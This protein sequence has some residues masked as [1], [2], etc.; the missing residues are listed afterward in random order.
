MAGRRERPL[1]PEAGPLERLAHGLRELRASAGGPTY[2]AMAARA[3]YSVSTLAAAARGDELPSLPVTL[4]YV[5]LCGGDPEEWEARW[6]GTARALEEQ[7]TGSAV[8]DDDGTDPPY[9][10]LARYEPGDRALFFGRDHLLTRL[11]ELVRG[12][13]VV[14]VAGASGSGKSSLLRAGLIPALRHPANAPVRCAGIRVLTPGA[15]P[16][17]THTPVLTAFPQPADAAGGDGGETPG[18]TDEDRARKDTVLVVDQFE[19]LFTLCQEQTE[20]ARFLELLLA[21]RTPDSGLRVV[22]AVRADFYAHCTE[23]PGLVEVLRTAHL[24]LGPMT[25]AE[26]R[27]A[28]VGPARAAGLIV[29]RELTARI[30]AETAVEPGGL[31]LMSHA[32]LEVWRRRRGRTLTLAAYESI[33]G[34]HGAVA[35]TAE[36]TYGR[37][38]PTQAAHARRLLLRLIT[39]GQGS[40]DTRRPTPRAELEADTPDETAQVLE[41]LTR[42]RLVTL[43]GDTADLAHEALITAWPRLANWIQED[44]HRLRVHRRLTRDAQNWQDLGQDTGAL[45]RGIRL[46][47]AREAFPATDHPSDLTALEH[48]FLTASQNHRLTTI[49]RARVLNSVL[50]CVL[51][52]ALLTAGIALWQRQNARTAEQRALTAQRTAESRQA[53]AHSAALFPKDPDLASLL[54]VHAYR[55]SPTTEAIVSLNK[56]A[57]RPLIRSSTGHSR[58]VWEA[59]FSRDG[60]RLVTVDDTGGTLL[61]DTGSG[62]NRRVAGNGARAMAALSPDGR[63]LASLSRHGTL[64]LRDVDSNRVRTIRTGHSEMTRLLLFSPDGRTLATGALDHTVR[65]W[66]A[67]TGKLRAVLTRDEERSRGSDETFTPDGR[68]FVTAAPGAG[69]V[70]LWDVRTGRLGVELIGH[71]GG[72]AKVEFSPDGRTVATAGFNGSVRLTDVASDQSLVLPVG[73]IE[74]AGAHGF[75]PDGRLFATAAPGAGKIRLWD[76]RT[77]KLRVELTGH[78]DGVARVAFSPDGRTVATAGLDGN[79]RLSDVA[80]GRSLVVLNGHTGV[81]HLMKFSRDGRTLMSVGSEGTVRWWQ[82]ETGRGDMTLTGHGK[83]VSAV[84]FSPDGGTLASVGGDRTV[85][86]WDTGT[87]GVRAALTGDPDGTH[88]VAYSPDGRTLA[89]G[90]ND[91]RVRLWDVDT[92]T[93][94]ATLTGHT[95]PVMKIAFSPDGRTL[96]SA[97]DDGTVRLWAVDTGRART[98]LKTGARSMRSVAFSP[99]GRTLATGGDDRKVRLWDVSTGRIRNV[100]SAHSEAVMDVTF[101]PDG[102]TLASA[103]LDDKVR[104]WD[105]TT[106]AIEATLPGGNGDVVFSPDG[107]TLATAGADWEIQLW[108]VATRTVRTTLPPHTDEVFSVAFSPD[109][110]TLAMGSDDKKVRLRRIAMTEPADALHK[111]CRAFQRNLTADERA[112][113]LPGHDSTPTCP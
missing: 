3:G 72:V 75:S 73:K 65:L 64:R 1:D 16:V 7:T 70:R 95:Q 87:G 5:T 9:R 12:H 111:I 99:D 49:R 41:N 102:R 112:Q 61:W 71:R 105:A 43:D 52:L 50:A 26:L 82:A 62:R 78:R 8:R 109:G 51:V 66:D 31:P 94:R 60:R 22:I 55:T 104:L 83:P 74:G 108:D 45:Y 81:A 106:G 86:L 90:G 68:F 57:D 79:I 92:G 56:A 76:V 21:A 39:P 6:H 23:H 107:R 97:S 24:A 19:E 84:A 17:A 27:Q 103:S 38:T 47:E 48:T 37:L 32:L 88:T 11:I 110:R 53:A 91:Q 40:P 10:G 101:S 35:D 98:V 58:E 42:A 44:R 93:A 34:I 67:S 18:A 14:I 77:G 30:V 54:A 46:A 36:H 69:K 96:A 25:P 100:L 13:R 63:I 85:R 59:A 15:R 29:E 28:V 2:R 89:T 20:R 80:S 113:Y 4:A 33:G